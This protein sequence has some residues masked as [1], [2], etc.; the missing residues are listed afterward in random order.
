M[1][2]FFVDGPA[3]GRLVGDVLE[4]GRFLRLHLNDGELDGV[5]ILAA[6]TARRMRSLTPGKPRDLGL[7][8][9]Q[10]PGPGRGSWVEHFGAGVG[11]CNVMCSTPS[12]AL[13]S[14]S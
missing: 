4:A 9:F 8:W 13:A 5:R 14:W 7:G 11:F 12:G 3:Y 2:R 6:D 10:S 1:S